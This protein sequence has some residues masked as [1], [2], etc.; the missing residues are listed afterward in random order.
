MNSQDL[1]V[2]LV[3]VSS[4]GPKEAHGDVTGVGFGQSFGQALPPGFAGA[5][6]VDQHRLFGAVANFVLAD[7]TAVD[8]DRLTHRLLSEDRSCFHH[9]LNRPVKLIGSSAQSSGG[10]K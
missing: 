1:G 8:R 6:A 5:P 3:Q 9:K 2:I 4:I 7:L 10:Q